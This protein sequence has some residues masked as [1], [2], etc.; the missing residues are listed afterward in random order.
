[1]KL[2]IVFITSRKEPHLEWVVEDLI[3]QKQSGDQIELIAVDFH[4]RQPNDLADATFAL[5]CGVTIRTSKPK[6]NIWQGDHKIVEDG[7]WWAISNARNTGITLAT[8]DYIA[9]L[10]DRCHLGPEWLTVV[11]QG[12][13]QR[14][15]AIAGTYE[16]HGGANGTTIDTRRPHA[17]SG[18]INC[19]GAWLYGCTSSMPLEWLLAVN[20]LEEGCDGMGGEDY[21]LG[22]MLSNI[23]KRIDYST[24]MAIIQERT[25]DPVTGATVGDFIFKRTDKG[26]A[27][28][29][30]SNA[31]LKRFGKLKRTEFTP[32]LRELRTHCLNGEPF[33]IPS[34]DV[35]Y[36]DWYDGQ[37]IREMKVR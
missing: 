21:T 33:P 6:P 24:K 5:A 11:R 36:K 3:G 25:L 30:K 37:L 20:G 16:K 19:G 1:M 28:N 12:C 18:K 8:H 17:P 9:F 27:P 4:G 10:D 31:A 13:T 22:L 26:I 2:S 34:P 15:S 7:H 23:G 29:D 35:D 32:N 14:V